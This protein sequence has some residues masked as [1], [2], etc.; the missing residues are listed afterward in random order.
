MNYKFSLLAIIFV[1]AVTPA[2]GIVKDLGV[3]GETYPVVEPD[4]LAELRQKAAQTDLNKDRKKILKQIKNFQP[5]DLHN[6]PRATAN[7]AKMVD[8]TYTLDRDLI[9][10]DGRVIYPRGYTFNPLDYVT[11]PGGMVII[12]GDD[13]DQL[14]WFKNSPYFENHQAR[15]LI[16]GGHAFGLIEKLQRP[17]FYLTDDIAKRLQ[18]SAVPSLVFQQG[19]KMQVH[20]FKVVDEE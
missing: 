9:D 19:N 6:L 7:L 8:M 13:P 2:W 12:D 17:V 14:N 20:E 15:L 16:S 1:F 10:Q 3:V 4:I 18:L 11:V 5:A